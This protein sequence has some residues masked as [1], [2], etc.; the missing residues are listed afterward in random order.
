MKLRYRLLLLVSV[1]L[2]LAVALTTWTV[3]ANARRAFAAVEEQ[4][5]AALVASFRREFALQGDEIARAV[6]RLAS[7][8]AVQR[9]AIEL[10]ARSSDPSMY[11]NEAASLAS[12]HGLDV[13]EI[14]G[15]DGNIVSSAQWPARFGYRHA[16]ATAVSESDRQ[17]AFL[18]SV[19]MPSEPA[20][21][22]VAIRTVEAGDR[23]LYLAGGR[24][25]N[26]SLLA[27]IGSA[28]GARVLLYRNLEPGF[29]SQQLIDAAGKVPDANRLEPLISRVRLLDREGTERVEW[30][31]GPETFQGIP[32]AGSSG[33]VL[34]VLLVGSSGRELNALVSGIRSSGLLFG[35]LGIALGL[36][37]SW[38]VASRVTGPVEELAAGARAVA[39]G[40]WNVRVDVNAGGE[41]RQL[42]DAFNTMT[43]ELVD[44]RERLVQAE[45]VASWREIARRLAHEL[46]NPLFPLR[47]TVENLQRAKTSA[48][49]EFDE[50][51]EESTRTLVAELNN[52]NGIISRFGDFAKM[53]TPRLEDVALNALVTDVMKLF[54]AQ[55]TAPG[56]PAIKA[57]RDLDERVTTV[58]ADPEQLGRALRNLLLN[59]I[60]AMPSG[61]AVTVRTVARGR[62]VQLQVADTGQGL[63]AEEAGRL[64][65]P[66]YTTKQH[67]TGLGLAIVQ[68]VVSDHHGKITVESA[69]GRGTTF[70][71]ELPA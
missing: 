24:R 4:R 44:Q 62:A 58:R 3:S 38:I 71:I 6:E 10:A 13:L 27:S 21:A 33:A 50:V 12:A 47:I 26:E 35:G 59:A 43:T 70:S 22:L 52:L 7:S 37:L 23:R 54:E 41:V 39:G 45:R 2:A 64:F 8:E 42:A 68:S 14:V 53:P 46:K 49:G 40:D 48:P 28:A 65:T 20:L 31:D 19:E 57:R 34:G 55:L 16:W 30:P 11:L 5:R 1:T 18:Q 66:Y 67:G 32:L 36:V 56:R 60:D 29:S 69:P 61:G 25:V 15:D 63:T 9:M 51:F 17:H